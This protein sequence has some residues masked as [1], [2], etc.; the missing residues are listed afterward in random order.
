MKKSWEPFGRYL[1]NSKA[2]Q[3]QLEWKWAGLAVLFSM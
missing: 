3:A 2:N 1:L